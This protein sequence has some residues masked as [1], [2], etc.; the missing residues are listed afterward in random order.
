[1]YGSTCIQF[2]L[3]HRIRYTNLTN[4]HHLVKITNFSPEE[5]YIFLRMN[6]KPNLYLSSCNGYQKISTCDYAFSNSSRDSMSAITDGNTYP[7]C[8]LMDH[9]TASS[10]QGSS[11][12][13]SNGM[14]T[15]PISL[16]ALS[17]GYNV[18]TTK[19]TLNLS[20]HG[21]VASV[22]L[23]HSGV[24][25]NNMGIFVCDCDQF[26]HTILF[27]SCDYWGIQPS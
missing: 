18:A 17:I 10:N 26:H 12:T 13:T 23:Y 21:L 1:M 5:A 8:S 9:T 24:N 4:T 27:P 14:G 22:A 15:N 6:L 20:S 2:R 7:G 11:S 16:E 25:S 3:N 19:M